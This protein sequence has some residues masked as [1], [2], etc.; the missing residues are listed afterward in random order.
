MSKITAPKEPSDADIFSDLTAPFN[1][2]LAYIG[3]TKA[4][5]PEKIPT[6]TE[7]SSTRR[8][9]HA[10]KTR[11]AINALTSVGFQDKL[12]CLGERTNTEAIITSVT[13][14]VENIITSTL[15]DPSSAKRV[16]AV[17]GPDGNAIADGLD[18]AGLMRDVGDDQTSMAN[19]DRR[20]ANMT[21]IQV[22]N[23]YDPS[24]I[25]P[26]P[27]PPVQ[28]RDFYKLKQSDKQVK[29]GNNQDITW[30]TWLGPNNFMD[31][32]KDVWL[33]NLTSQN[34]AAPIWLDQSSFAQPCRPRPT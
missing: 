29:Q 15:H 1:T 16:I 21:W 20:Q 12:R 9:I 23:E 28:S 27:V 8:H 3:N 19:A 24:D 2:E 4:I 17:Y 25:L 34:Q 33:D 31:T 32:P 18:D 7:T 22:L 11:S 13:C 6:D 10:L 14:Q 26:K 5:L 30:T